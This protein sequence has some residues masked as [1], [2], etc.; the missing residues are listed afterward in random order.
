MVVDQELSDSEVD[1]IFQAWPT[2]TR[3]DIFG[4]PSIVEASVSELAEAYNM[5]FAAVQKA[6]RGIGRSRARDQSTAGPRA[7]SA[8]QSRDD[9]ERLRPSWIVMRSC[10]ARASIDSTRCSPPTN[11]TRNPRKASTMP[12]TSISKDPE[13]LTMTVVAEFPVP[14]QRLWDA[15]ADPR[16]LE[17]FWGPPEY[18]STFR[19]ARLRRGRSL[20]LLHDRSGRRSSRRR[21]G[22]SSASTPARASRSRTASAR[23]RAPAYRRRAAHAHDLHL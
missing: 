23:R 3:R 19:Q 16:Q 6:R 1:R 17:K 20:G 10:G 12:I 5:S 11:P 18:P 7:H 4:A 9:R 2:A 13:A 22:R 8:R 14:V 15:Y 21:T